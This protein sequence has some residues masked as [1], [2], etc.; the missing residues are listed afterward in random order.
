M[1]TPFTHL[2]I[3]ESIRE[4]ACVQ[5]SPDSAINSLL[6]EQWPAFYLGSVAPDYQTICGI[7]RADTHFY[8][9]PPRTKSQGERTLLAQFP[10]LYPGN[11]IP[12]KQAAMV[13]AYLVHL[14]MDLAWQLEVVEPYFVAAP[15]FES[16]HQR[17]L[18]HL[19]LL[20]G[21][22]RESFDSLPGTA[23]ETL[24]RAN[25]DHCLPFADDDQLRDW[26]DYLMGQLQPQGKRQTAEI[27]A[28]RLQ[29]TAKE[30]TAK[31]NDLEWMHREFYSRV[32]VEKIRRQMKASIKPSLELITAYWI[33]QID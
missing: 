6:A 17:Y 14:R 31:L 9:M 3:A 4:L 23:A 12:P 25:P 22:D 20:A 29:M 26:R 19:I 27:F 32:P 1:P 8:G 30:F 28:R 21:L 16:D 15:H 13:A 10:D 5:S 18:M 7:A 33:G 24:A 2:E 11:Q